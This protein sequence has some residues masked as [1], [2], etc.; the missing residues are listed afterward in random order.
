MKS[1]PIQIAKGGALAA[2][3]VL[4]ISMF[5]TALHAEELGHTHTV[6]IPGETPAVHFEFDDDNPLTPPVVVSATSVEDVTL[7]FG[8]NATDPADVLTLVG[9]AKKCHPHSRINQVIKIS[10]KD[11]GAALDGSLSWQERDTNGDLIESHSLGFA[12]KADEDGGRYDL[13][14]CVR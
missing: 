7:S 10:L 3:F 13:S 8:W 5:G 12:A 11:A 2:A 4:V 14:L 9:K 1:T 6:T